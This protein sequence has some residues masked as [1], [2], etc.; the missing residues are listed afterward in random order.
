MENQTFLLRDAS[1]NEKIVDLAKNNYAQLQVGQMV[2]VPIKKPKI[3]T[4]Q[5]PSVQSKP[6]SSANLAALEERKNRMALLFEMGAISRKE[7]EAAEREYES[8]RAA[9]SSETESFAA[10]QMSQEVEYEIEYV[11]Q[12]QPTPPEILNGAQLAIKQAELSLNVARQE[13]QQTEVIAPVDGTIY[14]SIAV[15]DEVQAGSVVARVGDNRELWIEAEVTENQFEKISLGKLVS[16]V[17]EGNKLS[18]T[19]IEK[20]EP[21][22]EEE[23]KVEEKIET[24]ENSPPQ[25]AENVEE[26]SQ[27]AQNVQ[28]P[29]E[30]STENIQNVDKENP[31]LKDKY[32]IKFSLPTERNFECKPNINVAVTIKN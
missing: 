12:L 11:D 24:T 10:P 7:K 30:N 27:T 9:Q 32:I 17:I 4:V 6:K 3:K 15:D 23:I 20:I 1:E 16:Y 5:I 21:T 19:V 2:K 26:N 29:A 28:Q 8:A 31:E 25:T 13:S 14:Y 22:A 18:G